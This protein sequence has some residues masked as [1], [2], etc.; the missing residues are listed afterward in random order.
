MASLVILDATHKTRPALCY[1]SYDQSG[2]GYARPIAIP[3]DG[4]KG[5][6]RG[7]SDRRR[8]RAAV[9]RELASAC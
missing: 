4:P 3:S 2:P 6:R 7:A 8:I 1:T 9:P 5:L